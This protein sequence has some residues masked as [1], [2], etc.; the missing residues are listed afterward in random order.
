VSVGERGYPVISADSHFT[1]PADLWL[2]R[3]DPAYRDR[4]PHVVHGETTDT[5]VCDGAPM[6]PVGVMHGV[7]YHGGDVP[8]A[9]RYADIPASGWDLGAR[10]ADLAVDGVSAEVLYP[11][12][13][14]RFFT[15]EDPA[16]ANACIRAYNSFAADFCAE[17][18][19]RFRAVGVIHLDDMAGALDE[20]ERCRDLGL[21]G[22]MIAV[23]PAEAVPY[24][25]AAYDPFWA[26]AERLGMPVS[27]HTSTPRRIKAD[28]T[29]LEMF[30][31]YQ[32]VQ[33]LIIGMILA[34]TF[35]RFPG[36]QLVSVENDAGWAAHLIERMDYVHGKAR[37]RNLNVGHHNERTPSEYWRANVSYTFM[38]DRTA[39]VARDIIGVDRLLWSS[40]FPHGDSTWPD[41]QQVIDAELGDIPAAERKAILHDNAARLYGFPEA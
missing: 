16:F 37:A 26:A 22:A 41:S 30:L 13:G 34:G 3:I 15:I 5:I 7:R 31:G 12:V 25:D 2:E 40:D 10:L 38:R 29:P 21:V 14:M 6:F 19:E 9:G 33:H 23:H 27:L 32:V 36:L 18:P 28:R 17:R 4:A 35:D 39:I 24:H 20:M 11:T 1:E 8:T